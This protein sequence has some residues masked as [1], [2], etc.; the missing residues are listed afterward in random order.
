M[1][2]TADIVKGFVKSILSNQFDG[3]VESPSFHEECWDLCC[4]SNQ[5]VAIAAPRGH[6]KSSAITLGYGLSTLLFRER[7]F[8][9][10]VSDTESQA[11]LFLGTFKQAL[12]DNKD[13]VDL[14][15]LK[16]DEKGN[17]KFIKDTE[18]DII[19]EFTDGHKFR[20]IAKGAEQK[21]RG[22][23]W[24]GSRP[25][26]IMCH[27]KGTQIY[28]PSLGWMSNQDHPTAKEVFTKDAYKI[29]YE[30]GT[31]EVVSGDH[32]YFVEGKGWQFPWEMK[33]GDNVSENI[34]ED[35]L[36]AILRKEQKALQNTT[37][38]K[39]LK[40]VWQTGIRT[41]VMLSLLHVRSGMPRIRKLLMRMLQTMHEK[42][43]HGKQLIVPKDALVN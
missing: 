33:N 25:D 43:Q 7:K 5:F 21:L 12:Q 28:D 16:L 26:I 22:L 19:I 3:A 9:L 1:R 17:V 2:V 18:N 41:I 6:A 4:S 13:L 37:I 39:K 35:T 40:N 11:A 8:M 23:L 20:V 14:F 30:D 15:D 42:T 36:N 34:N 31:I 24:N 29:E 10:L 38:R 32:R 27:E